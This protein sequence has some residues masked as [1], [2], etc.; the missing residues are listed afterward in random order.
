MSTVE[1]VYTFVLPEGQTTVTL[2]ND[3]ITGTLTTFPDGTKKLE[4][5]PKKK[6]QVKKKLPDN[7]V[8]RP[9]SSFY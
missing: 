4:A 6:L 1:P 9:A 5:A 2:T 7:I 8:W 3:N